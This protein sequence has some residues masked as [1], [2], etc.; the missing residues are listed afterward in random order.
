[1]FLP[2]TY[3]G[4]N[5]L[6]RRRHPTATRHAR[7]EEPPPRHAQ[8]EERARPRPGLLSRRA[9]QTTAEAAGCRARQSR[10]S[11]FSRLVVNTSPTAIITA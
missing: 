6:P 3:I 11:A 1:M 9:T 4:E 7:Q 8:Q 5:L 10:K 2:C